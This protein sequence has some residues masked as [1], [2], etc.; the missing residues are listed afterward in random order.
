MGVPPSTQTPLVLV[1]PSERA[2]AAVKAWGEAISRLARVDAISTAS[3]APD[4]A[5]LLVVRGETVALPL[6]GV[7]DLGA[8]RARLDKEI[9]KV[10]A[11]IAKVVA[12]LGNEDF[13][14]RAPE[15]VVAEH[16]ERRETFEARLG[17]LSQA[18]DRLERV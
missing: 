10:R 1:A 4:G 11:E 15:D 14:A 6:K 12:K 17:K 3:A 8:E 13:L 16:E 18:R 9:H 7:V 5:L 2:E